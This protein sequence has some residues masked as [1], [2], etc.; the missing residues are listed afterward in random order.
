MK[1]YANPLLDSLTAEGTPFEIAHTG[2]DYFF[3]NAPA[4][5]NTLIDTAR[6]ALYEAQGLVRREGSRI[7]VTDAGMPL[8]EA[9]LGELVPAELVA[10]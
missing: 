5:L 10:A 6:L 3:R 1:K 2:D 4:S 7:I 8:L 9:L